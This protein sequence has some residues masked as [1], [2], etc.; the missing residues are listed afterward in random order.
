MLLTKPFAPGE[1]WTLV[2]VEEPATLRSA[3]TLSSTMK[4]ALELLI[5]P[6]TRNRVPWLSKDRK[7]SKNPSGRL[8]RSFMQSGVQGF[9]KVGVL[10]GDVGL[11]DVLH[12][13]LQLVAPEIRA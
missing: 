2:T 6:L 3:Y 9:K 13:D 11:K 8:W 7:A 1:D 4:L 12:D 10:H 5:T